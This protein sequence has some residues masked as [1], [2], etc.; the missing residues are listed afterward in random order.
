M[1]SPDF[2]IFQT[3]S[4][5]AAK[6]EE[7]L[8]AEELTQKEVPTKVSPSTAIHIFNLIAID[9]AQQHMPANQEFKGEEN[10]L[11]YDEKTRLANKI[12]SSTKINDKTK[13]VTQK[14]ILFTG[15][16]ILYISQR[17][18]EEYFVGTQPIPDEIPDMHR[19]PIEEGQAI[20][21]HHA[22]RAYLD[23]R[24]AFLQ[25]GGVLPLDVDNQL[26]GD[27]SEGN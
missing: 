23:L 9:L 26:F 7:R 11:T 1:A 17:L 18:E 10:N 8:D 25:A 22:L 3:V 5:I 24:N 2:D 16:E 4:E 6:E 19:A 27:I 12:F 21:R 14:P 20:M 15:I 13:S